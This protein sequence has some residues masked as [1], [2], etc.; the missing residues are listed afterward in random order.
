MRQFSVPSTGELCSLRAQCRAVSILHS[1]VPAVL[2]VSSHRECSDFVISPVLSA[3]SGAQGC[4]TTAAG[5]S[6]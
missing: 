6:E 2:L 4:A 5:F 3:R 1:A